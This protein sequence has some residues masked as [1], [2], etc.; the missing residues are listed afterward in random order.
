MKIEI[1]ENDDQSSV[2]RMIKL[3]EQQSAYPIFVLD[4]CSTENKNNCLE[5]FILDH[6]RFS[7]YHG[8]VILS[9]DGL[10]ATCSGIYWDG[11]HVYGTRH[12]SFGN[13]EIHFRI[14]NKGSNNL[15]F[16][17]TTASCNMPLQ[18]LTSPY[19]VG[20]CIQRYGCRVVTRLLH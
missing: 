10:L 7:G 6:E 5:T 16:G 14:E 20:W 15:F 13:H 18:S 17:I 12:Y 8:K 19:A 9:D 11:S 3:N 1:V 4:E 2:I